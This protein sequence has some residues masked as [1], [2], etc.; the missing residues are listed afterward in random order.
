MEASTTRGSRL[1]ER[2]TP[3]RL[4]LL[5]AFGLATLVAVLVPQG[6]ESATPPV[7]TLLLAGVLIGVVTV[8][9]LLWGVQSDL[10]LPAKVAVYAGGYNALIV[11]VKFVLAPEGFYDVNRD[12]QLT[13]LLTVGDN[14]GAVLTGVLVFGLYLVA[15]VVVYRL[16]RRGLTGLSDQP[17]RARQGLLAVLGGALL[18]SAAGG[19]V[20]VFLVIP[21]LISGS[22][23][24][25]L[26]FV[27]TSGASLLIALALAGAVTLAALA[28]RSVAERAAVVGDAAVLISFFWLG[29]YFLALYHALWVVYVLIL[30]S[31]WP[32]R[33][34]VPK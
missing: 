3:L 34:V 12:V 11:L 6:G 18:L 28:F 10:G 31:V 21:V 29:L 27:F 30:T 32:L 14:E 8:G 2:A 22:A 20:L 1:G 13:G 24:E 25:Y 16:C 26:E 23:V 9:A 4:K 15:Y 5:V 7:G 17:A 19:G 33:A